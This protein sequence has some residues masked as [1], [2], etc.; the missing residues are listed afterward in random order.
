[1]ATPMTTAGGI[2]RRRTA[3]RGCGRLSA[4]LGR[5]AHPSGKRNGASP[6]SASAGP[7]GQASPFAALTRVIALPRLRHKLHLDGRLTARIT[8][9]RILV[10]IFVQPLTTRKAE[11]MWPTGGGRISH[12]GLPPHCHP[13]QG[14]FAP[15]PHPSPLP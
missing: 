11:K 3:A 5:R 12:S 1:M 2:R 14:G 6:V 4:S 10:R 15:N 13:K 7:N 8:T 9:I